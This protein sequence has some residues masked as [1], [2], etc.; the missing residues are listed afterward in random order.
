VMITGANSGGKSTLLRALGQAQLMLQCGML[1]G[2]SAYR[3]SVGA[4]VF[5]HFIREEDETMSSGKLDEELARMD[6]IVGWIR[7]GSILLLNESFAAT[8]EREGS[9]IAR[10]IVDALLESGVR[11]LFVTHQYALAHIF[12]SRGTNNA[13]FLRAERGVDGRRS[14]RVIKGEPLATSFG[15]DLY[16][17]IGGFF[18]GLTEH[19][20]NEHRASMPAT[21]FEDA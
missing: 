7:P 20:T 13:I 17:K 15:E 12:F 8:N 9:E 11:V 3:S 16:Q 10:Q 6:R 4:S 5:T 21:E 14:Y 1:V 18:T 19:T 2:A